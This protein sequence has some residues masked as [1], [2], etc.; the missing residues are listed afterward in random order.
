MG[1]KNPVSLDGGWRALKES[2]LELNEAALRVC[3]RRG[4]LNK[5]GVVVLRF[6]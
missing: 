6:A 1:Y 2:G 4:F 3:D 5:R